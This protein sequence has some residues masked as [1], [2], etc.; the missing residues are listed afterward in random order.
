MSQA[1]RAITH[2]HRVRAAAGSVHLR[3]GVVVAE[4]SGYG[5]H[6]A[7]LGLH[8]DLHVFG[9]TVPWLQIVRGAFAGLLVVLAVWGGRAGHQADK[10]L[11]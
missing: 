8:N 4:G 2:P 10:T 5:L 9:R 1:P 6:S 11:L 7:G 3:R